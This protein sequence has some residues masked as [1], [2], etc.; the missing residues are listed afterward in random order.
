MATKRAA[1]GPK[2]QDQRNP[3]PKSPSPSDAQKQGAERI[4]SIPNDLVLAPQ[5]EAPR[6]PTGRDQS[7]Q[8]PNGVVELSWA[9]FDRSVQKLARTIRQSWEPQAVV[10]VAHGGVY[11]GGA[12]AG[13]LGVQF[14]PVRISRRSR[15]KADRTKNRALDPQVSEEMPLAIKGLRVLIVDDIASSGD[16]LELATAL[17]RKVGAKEVKTACLV[18]RPEGFTPDHAG[19]S[20]DSLFVFPWDYEPGMGEAHF[21]DDPD[22]AGA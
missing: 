4:V 8:K 19:M 11:V 14:F 7:R 21:D 12:L 16:T 17:A 3:S 10:G 6:Q 22:K 9:E 13:A 2:S 18:A 1:P 15:D 5:V 20:T